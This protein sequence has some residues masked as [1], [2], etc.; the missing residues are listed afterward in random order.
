MIRVRVSAIDCV[1]FVRAWCGKTILPLMARNG[2]TQPQIPDSGKT[3]RRR[4]AR[5]PI[6]HV[7]VGG[8]NI[9]RKRY[10]TAGGFSLVSIFSRPPPPPYTI[11]DYCR[12]GGA[13][14]RAAESL[15]PERIADIT[16]I[17]IPELSVHC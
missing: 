13:S 10:K 15:K 1:S 12:R 2:A 11:P 8:E 9:K 4:G 16:G 17:R 7:R 6:N 5:F 3:L 14:V